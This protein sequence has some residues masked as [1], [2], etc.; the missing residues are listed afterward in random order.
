MEWALVTKEYQYKEG[1]K[2][3]KNF[4]RAMKKLFRVRKQK[5]PISA[6]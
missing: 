2:A 3:T 5:P 4:E 6:G 1:A